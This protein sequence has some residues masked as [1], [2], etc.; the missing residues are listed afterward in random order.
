MYARQK[1]NKA[2]ATTTATKA[3]TTATKATTNQG[4]GSGFYSG[5]DAQGWDLCD[6]VGWG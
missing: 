6:A 5:P 3:T 1:Q 4:K 2:A